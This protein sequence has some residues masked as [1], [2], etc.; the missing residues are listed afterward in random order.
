MVGNISTTH[1]VTFIKHDFP[2]HK[3]FHNDPLYLEV[4]VHKHKIRRVLVDDEVIL[5][6]C[7]LKL[8]QTLGFSKGCVD[9]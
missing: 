5:N 8:V 1:Q 9:T 2:M 4:Y 6:I 7:T 3:P